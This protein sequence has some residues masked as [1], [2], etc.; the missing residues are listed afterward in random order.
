MIRQEA[1]EHAAYGGDADGRQRHGQ[2]ARAARVAQ[3][4][5]ARGGHG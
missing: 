3:P 5:Q 2:R 1:A 4:Q